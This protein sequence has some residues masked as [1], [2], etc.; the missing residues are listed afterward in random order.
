MIGCLCKV[1][2]LQEVRS[3][4]D[5]LVLCFNSIL[6]LQEACVPFNLPTPIRIESTLKIVESTPVTGVTME[7]N[8][9]QSKVQ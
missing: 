3:M 7:R 4:F 2:L 1:D 8:H 6:V 9:I 5:D